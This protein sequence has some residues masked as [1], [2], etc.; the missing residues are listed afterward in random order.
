MRGMQLAVG[1]HIAHRL[2][3]EHDQRIDGVVVDR[4]DIAVGGIDIEAALELDFRVQPADD[5]LGLG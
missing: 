1:R 2:T 5:P 3:G 4:V